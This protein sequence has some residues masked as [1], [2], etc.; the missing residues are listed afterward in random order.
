MFHRSD[1]ARLTGLPA[2]RSSKLAA[3][4]MCLLLIAAWLPRAYAARC[5]TPGER[6]TF[7]G[8]FNR[9][10]AAWEHQ[11][12]AASAALFSANAEYREDAFSMPMRGNRAILAYWSRLARTQ[13]DVHASHE[14][15][16]A[17][18][19]TGIVHW[20]ASFVRTPS[21]KRVRLDGIA[22]V[23]LDRHRKSVLFLEW[24]NIE[25]K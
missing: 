15:L 5:D 20:K 23:T 8:W 4:T 7:D 10:D 19:N 18:G 3:A 21:G 11:D 9:F 25:Q 6:A 16:S 14:V 17:C 1:F 12:A 2:A 24:W 13:R 22:E